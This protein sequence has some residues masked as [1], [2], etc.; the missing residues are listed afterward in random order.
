MPGCISDD[1]LASRCREVAICYVD[2]YPLLA[3]GTKPVRQ[4]REIDGS[5][6]A[7]GRGFGDG[8]DLVFIDIPRVVK[9]TPDQGGF[10][11]IDAA[12]GC[13]PQQILGPLSFEKLFY[14]ERSGSFQCGSGHI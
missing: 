9:K 5:R 2:R 1:E 14:G 10:A 3:L 4:K 13:E 8:L 6:S 7:V 12:S 11:V